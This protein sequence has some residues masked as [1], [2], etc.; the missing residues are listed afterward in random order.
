MNEINNHNAQEEMLKVIN[1]R[2]DKKQI[3]DTM[4]GY[5]NGHVTSSE[6]N[7]SIMRSL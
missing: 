4:I 3:C 7:T 1:H 5:K 6:L 2:I